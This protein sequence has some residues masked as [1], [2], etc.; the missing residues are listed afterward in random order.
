METLSPKRAKRIS[1]VSECTAPS[2]PV[3]A[4]FSGELL[5]GRRLIAAQDVDVILA[6]LHSRD[7]DDEAAQRRAEGALLATSTTPTPF[8]EDELRPLASHAA[9]RNLA[10]LIPDIYPERTETPPPHEEESAAPDF[11]T[12]TAVEDVF[13]QLSDLGRGVALAK[14]GRPAGNNTPAAPPAETTKRRSEVAET[15]TFAGVALPLPPQDVARL[16]E[17]TGGNEVSEEYYENEERLAFEAWE[18]DRAQ[19]TQS[20]PL[21]NRLFLDSDILA[22]PNLRDAEGGCGVP[23]SDPPKA[24]S[25]SEGGFDWAS[26]RLVQGAHES[27][28]HFSAEADNYYSMHTR[29]AVLDARA[30]HRKMDLERRARQC[31]YKHKAGD[32]SVPYRATVGRHVFEYEELGV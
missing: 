10:T 20:V 4:V 22:Y 16:H 26:R 23:W 9:I 30:E 12:P 18:K 3:A 14:G 6:Q 13:A 8:S 21:P 25:V 24:M 7:S 29:L 17:L 27:T 2:T 15:R 5:K 32:N 19:R 31:H 1:F 11:F 28:E